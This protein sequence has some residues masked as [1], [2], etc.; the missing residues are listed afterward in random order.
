MVL[1]HPSMPPATRDRDGGKAGISSGNER[2][3]RAYGNRH[4]RM[5]SRPVVDGFPAAFTP[6][7]D[8]VAFLSLCRRRLMICQSCGVEAPTKYVAFYQNIGA[9]VMRFTRSA[10]GRMCK[11]SCTFKP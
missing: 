4:G 10:E 6:I 1:E 9:L 8:A 2:D 3:E 7:G 5:D 11:S